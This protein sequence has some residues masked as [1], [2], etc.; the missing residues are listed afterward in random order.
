MFKKVVGI[1]VV[2]A[3][4]VIVL[5]LGFLAWDPWDFVD[6]SLI[7][8]NWE[9]LEGFFQRDW[10]VE[11]E[12][13]ADEPEEPEIVEEEVVADEKVEDDQVGNEHAVTRCPEDGEMREALGFDDANIYP[14]FTGEAVRWDSCKWNWQ[15]YANSDEGITFTLP[16]NWQATVTK[17]GGRVI[18]VWRGPAEVGDVVGFT[19]RYVPA[20][21]QDHWV[22]GDCSLL[23]QEHAFGQRRNPSYQT[24]S[25]NVECEGFDPRL[26]ACPTD[27]SEI[28]ALIGGDPSDWNKPDWE[29]GA[30]VFQADPG[31]YHILEIPKLLG[32]A[33]EVIRL[34]YWDEEAGAPATLLPG[35]E[36]LGL[37]QASFHCHAEE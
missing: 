28:A 16:S 4:V 30:W 31:E 10:G 18:E 37:N 19:L 8:F 26:D 32:D 17:V 23:S 6:I 5:S 36:G 22:Y 21:A 25:G 35:N 27:K 1:L 33:E 13:P 2:V 34:D 14:V 12:E 29:L 24:T 15:M 9:A 3:L 20:Y 11:A 7:Q